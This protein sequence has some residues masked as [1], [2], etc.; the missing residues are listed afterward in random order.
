[1]RDHAAMA[2]KQLRTKD[3]SDADRKRL[4]EAVE[5]AR[6]AAGLEMLEGGRAG[7]GQ[8]FLFEI[9][10]ALPAWTEDS[11]RHILEGGD[12]P[13]INDRP[14]PAPEP[15]PRAPGLSDAER[16][17]IHTLSRRGWPAEDI[18]EALDELRRSSADQ[19]PVE[20]Q[21]ATDQERNAITFGRSGETGTE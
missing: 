9:A 6:R 1:M 20:Q 7:V 14:P 2:R 19:L 18:A 13:P 21:T 16:S 11:P 5:S 10:Q 12:P 17:L 3:Y 15:A 8:A 4:G